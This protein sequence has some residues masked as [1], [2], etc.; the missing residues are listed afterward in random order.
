MLIS[1][2]FGF[3]ILILQEFWRAF[4]GVIN[5]LSIKQLIAPECRCL[6]FFFPFSF[7]IQAEGILNGQ[8][9]ENQRTTFVKQ[10]K[11]GKVRQKSLS[12]SLKSPKCCHPVTSLF[13]L[14][15]SISCTNILLFKVNSPGK[16]LWALRPQLSKTSNA[17]RM[18]I[19]SCYLAKHINV[20]L[21]HFLDFT[22]ILQWA[23]WFIFCL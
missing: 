10:L 4:L 2:W 9:I 22:L 11:L 7:Q 3:R 16:Y 13:E 1:A 14:V 19:F 5:A 8:S 23:N 18:W 6:H 15:V 12:K 21:A 17:E 20:S